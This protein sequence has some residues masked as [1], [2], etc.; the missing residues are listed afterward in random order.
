MKDVEAR[1]ISE[2]MKNSR[3]SD[4][5]LSRELGVSQPTVSRMI[6]KLEKEGVIKEYTMIPDYSKLGFGLMS[7]T[8][9]KMKGALSEGIIDDM[10]KRARNMMNENPPA[11]I[12]GSAGMGCGAD[13]V[14]V[15]FHRDYNEYTEFMRD[16]REFPS[17]NIDETKSFVI[18]LHDKNHQLQP[19]S[20]FQV[21]R[22]LAQVREG[23]QTERKRR[24]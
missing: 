8:F 17:L 24:T 15:A 20:F 11:L 21:A 23:S 12:L 4:R 14:A 10:K 6:R 16:I 7:M 3:R 19:L 22:Y 1:L 18:N 2:L 13:Y 5:E 9:T